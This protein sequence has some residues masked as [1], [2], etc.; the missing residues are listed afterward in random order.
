MINSLR[1]Y[2][3][4]A[5]KPILSPFSQLFRLG[6]YL[7]NTAYDK[8]ILSIEK[9]GIPV[10][11]VGNIAVG[12]SGKSP[13]IIELARILTEMDADFRFAIVSRGYGRKGRG[14]RIVADREQI[15]LDAKEGGDEPNMIA[16]ELPGIP[17][18]VAEKRIQGILEARCQFN[19]QAALLDDAFQHR[20]LHRDLDLVLLDETTDYKSWKLMPSGSL[21]ELPHAL[22]R[23]H[24][25]VLSGNGSPSQKEHYRRWISQFSP[26]LVISGHLVPR[27][28]WNLREN[29]QLAFERLQSCAVAAVC[30]IAKPNRF[31]QLLESLGA[32]LVSRTTL[33]D[34]AWLDERHVPL[35]LSEAKKSGAEAVVI[36]MKDAVKWVYKMQEM[37]IW[38]LRTLWSWDDGSVEVVREILK[39]WKEAVP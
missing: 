11:S 12:G 35:I 32:K 3:Y 28:I 8:G 1:L 25:F 29:R 26:A 24:L 5:F 18:V 37:P 19:I 31:F 4:Q 34:H 30:G 15:I 20:S 2:N 6:V 13:L 21:R 10:L 38:V 16:N 7:R 36:T 39:T 27:D 33:P 17:V 22:K 23:A 9:A 14:V